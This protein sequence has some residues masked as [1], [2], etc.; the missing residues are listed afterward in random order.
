MEHFIG[1]RLYD[2]ATH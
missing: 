2:R 1:P